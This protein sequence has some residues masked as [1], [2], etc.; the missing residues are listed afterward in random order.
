MMT[1]E[2]RELVARSGLLMDRLWAFPETMYELKKRPQ[3]WLRLTTSMSDFIDRSVSYLA[4]LEKS[5]DLGFLGPKEAVGEITWKRLNELAADGVDVEKAFDYAGSVMARSEFSYTPGHVQMWQREHPVLGMFKHFIFR[6]AEFVSNIRK[7]AKEVKDHPDPEAFIQEQVSKGNYEY[8]D[9]V[10]KY[11]RILVSLTGAAAVAAG[12]GG[13]LFGRF[14]PFHLGR[15][16]SPPVM[17]AADTVD[18]IRRTLNG[19]A[20][21][22]EWKAWA[23]DFFGS[24]TPGAGFAVRQADPYQ[25]V[26]ITK[27]RKKHRDF[28]TVP[29]E[30]FQFDQ[31]PQ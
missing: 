25:R 17:F 16:L 18:L 1:D 19:S 8:I 15:L 5:K 26:T 27:P 12:I 31:M 21:E 28:E 9:A 22:D 2:G 30:K 4:A 29:V 13:P 23:W 3:G 24:F 11:R 20:K 7:I 14:W 6:E 10:A